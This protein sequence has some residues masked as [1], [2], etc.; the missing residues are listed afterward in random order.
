M[1]SDVS[2]GGS[3]L[4]AR[5]GLADPLPDCS[6]L[7]TAELTPL[8]FGCS[9]LFRTWQL[10]CRRANNARDRER[11]RKA[12]CNSLKCRCSF[13]SVPL[14]TLITPGSMG[15][16]RQ[17]WIFRDKDLQATSWRLAT[18]AITYVKYKTS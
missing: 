12:P 4:K 9:D 3:L 14:V 15:M 5:L 10:A 2:W 17:L 6:N 16:N 18:I 13:S 1:Q 8:H 7:K 11:N